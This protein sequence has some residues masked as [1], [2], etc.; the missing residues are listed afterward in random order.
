MFSILQC[1]Y[2]RAPLP[3]KSR[4]KSCR[5][6]K[7]RNP[8]PN[9]AKL[10][11]VSRAQSIGDRAE[12]LSQCRRQCSLSTPEAAEWSVKDHCKDPGRMLLCLRPPMAWVLTAS[13]VCAEL[14]KSDATGKLLCL[15]DHAAS[16]PIFGHN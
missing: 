15:G 11:V 3:T 13:W 12:T 5:G 4:L 9:D 10:M 8:Q 2:A 6:A 16:F 14:C 7:Q 1:C